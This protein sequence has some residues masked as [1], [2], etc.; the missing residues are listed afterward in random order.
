MACVSAHH[1]SKFT[2]IRLLF[3]LNCVLYTVPRIVLPDTLADDL[4]GFLE[5]IK[6]DDFWGHMISDISITCS[7]INMLLIII[8]IGIVSQ[9]KKR[10]HKE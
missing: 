7:V 4:Y 9:M 1:I 10:C 2:M 8:Q 3:V 6:Y 5:L